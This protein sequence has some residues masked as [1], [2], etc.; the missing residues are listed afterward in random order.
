[1][2]L[3]VLTGGKEKVE[4]TVQEFLSIPML[5][6]AEIVAGREGAN[7]VVR[8][9]SLMD[10][11]YGYRY[12]DG[13]MLA[14]TSGYVLAS[15]VDQV[16]SVIAEMSQ[17][18][19]SGI[20]LKRKYFGEQ[21][22][23]Q[24]LYAAN[25][26]HFPLIQL[27]DNEM[28][29]YKLFDY[30]NTHVY[31]RK[32]AE[33][34]RL[35]SVSAILVNAIN[36]N[37][38]SN[39]MRQLYEW[40]GR[41]TT[42]IFKKEVLCYPVQTRLSRIN[43][44]LIEQNFKPDT[45]HKGIYYLDTCQV[46]VRGVYN[47]NTQSSIWLDETETSC[48]LNE[49]AILRAANTACE[50]GTSQIIAFEQDE[51]R[52]RTKLMKDILSGKL[53]SI[54][55]ATLQ[56]RRLHFTIPKK[57]QVL[58]I[59]STSSLETAIEQVVQ[60]FF[61]REN[62]HIMECFYKGQFVLLLPSELPE[63]RQFVLALHIFLK[64]HFPRE[65]FQ[66]SVGRL[67]DF[68]EIRTS[69]QQACLTQKVSLLS[70]L[71]KSNCCFFDEIGIFRLCGP[72]PAG[73]LFILCRELLEPLIRPHVEAD[74]LDTLQAFFHCRCNY[75]RTGEVLHLHPNTVRYR[76]RVAEK[77]CGFS[78]ENY[79]DMLNVQVALQLLPVIFPNSWDSSIQ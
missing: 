32:R 41:E 34:L 58:L 49:I 67:M 21:L 5:R 15:N 4:L 61:R 20:T 18:G 54:H 69:Y 72:E 76:L 43:L 57:A 74:I 25:L 59:H 16:A 44:S 35:D 36:T 17:R 64:E 22:P 33:F 14:V 8:G 71:K 13:G 62:M 55:D 51:L 50:I 12:L 78:L 52:L 68:Y 48:D 53:T 30:F 60:K 1:M 24:L 31:C 66:L 47:L 37:G 45:A 38:F 77:M 73:E 3:Y 42:V 79:E 56:A 65:E 70:N 11:I 10:S 23:E 63:I 28:Q 27:P 2:E 40:T 26:Y 46:K 6:G 7:R 39:L 19:L 29:F 9:L 75:S